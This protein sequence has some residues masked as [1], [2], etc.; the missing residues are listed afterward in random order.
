MPRLLLLATLLCALVLAACGGGSDGGG[1]GAGEAGGGDGNARERAE[2]PFAAAGDD[3][4]RRLAKRFPRVRADRAERTPGAVLQGAS[5][6][7]DFT[8]DLHAGLVKLD[9]PADAQQIVAMSQR[10]SAAALSRKIL[11]KRV[12]ALTR[13]GEVQAAFRAALASVKAQQRM[14]RDIAEPLD[15][16]MRAYGFKVCGRPQTFGAKKTRS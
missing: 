1:G 14:I 16:R 4:C 2:K 10:L 8:R 11:Q 13:D 6:Y 7:R 5:A 3:L 15:K 9:A 12:V